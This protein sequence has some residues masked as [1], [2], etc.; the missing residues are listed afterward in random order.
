MHVQILDRPRYY[1]MDRAISRQ[2][3]KK[4]ISDN[5]NNC[6]AVDPKVKVKTPAK[7][8]KKNK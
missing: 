1:D 4:D 7:R 2:N 6:N 5:R 3:R 8:M